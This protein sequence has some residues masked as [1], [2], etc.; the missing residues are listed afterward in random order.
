ME[1]H[2]RKGMALGETGK[3]EVVF[4]KKAQTSDAKNSEWAGSDLGPY[5]C[6][7]VCMCVIA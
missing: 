6:T 3:G 4:R 1:G 5:V 7:Q 2:G